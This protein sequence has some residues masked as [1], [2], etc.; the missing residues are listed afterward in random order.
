MGLPEHI[1]RQKERIKEL[2]AELRKFLDE[3]KSTQHELVPQKAKE[4]LKLSQELY[5]R[6]REHLGDDTKLLREVE[7]LLS[8]YKPGGI[9]EFQKYYGS[10]EV[11]EKRKDLALLHSSEVIRNQILIFTAPHGY[12]GFGQNW[13]IF[14]RELED[15]ER[16]VDSQ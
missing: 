14:Y 2:V 7:H 4:G 9:Q 8:A 1:Q 5:I 6:C 3:L 13:V 11:L 12:T 16:I 10:F 15:I